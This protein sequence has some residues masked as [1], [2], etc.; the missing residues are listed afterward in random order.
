M[1]RTEDCLPSRY[2]ETKAAVISGH[3]ASGPSSPDAV[4]GPSSP[5]AHY[6]DKSESSTQSLSVSLS[7][8]PTIPR[9]ESSSLH[10]TPLPLSLKTSTTSVSHPGK[11]TIILD[12][13]YSNLLKQNRVR[14]THTSSKETH[15][16]SKEETQ[17]I[18][19][20]QVSKADTHVV[21]KGTGNVRADKARQTR[22][23]GNTCNLK[24]TRKR[25]DGFLGSD[26]VTDAEQYRY[27]SDIAGIGV[28]RLGA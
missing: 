10:T 3:V 8:S 18:N 26:Q 11:H 22:D 2:S 24:H 16:Q 4:S 13:R 28:R 7:C 25:R 21:T 23:A 17:T 9:F 1:E 20:I 6:S 5:D 19:I 27:W 12:P 14:Q 15:D